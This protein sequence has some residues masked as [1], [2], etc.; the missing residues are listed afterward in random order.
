MPGAKLICS[1]HCSETNDAVCIFRPA[2]LVTMTTI[3]NSPPLKLVALAAL[4][5]TWS[6]ASGCYKSPDFINPVYNC[7]CGS[8]AFNGSDYALK[9]AEAVVPD[10][11]EPLS[12]SY[13]IVADLRTADE[14]D[15]HVPAHDITFQ[16]SFDVLDDVVFY[17]QQ[18]EVNHLVQ[19]INQ[20]DDLFPVRDYKATDGSIVIDPAYSG[21]AEEVT[22]NLTLREW[23]DSTLVG[24]PVAFT[25]SFTG[26]IE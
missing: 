23:V 24:L 14:V 5:L 22:F 26:N 16:F 7:E 17:V 13:H 11:L 4:A 1:I 10:S 12:R 18:E 9:M 20:G 8:I 15:A 21:G 2:I 3:F 25:G 19:V 6:L